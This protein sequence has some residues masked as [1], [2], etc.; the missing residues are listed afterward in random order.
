MRSVLG[1]GQCTIMRRPELHIL[2]T[3][4]SLRLSVAAII[5]MALGLQVCVGDL[6]ARWVMKSA[7]EFQ[8]LTLAYNL[9]QLC[10]IW[11]P[12]FPKAV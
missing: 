8:N 9:V 3:G 4:A 11:K 10:K 1:C 12:P 7:I 5:I 2:L 6:N